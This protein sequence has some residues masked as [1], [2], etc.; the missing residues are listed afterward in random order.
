M[1]RLA[2]FSVALCLCVACLGPGT[3]L[4]GTNGQQLDVLSCQTHYIHVYGYNQNNY[5]NPDG[6]RF[7]LSGCGWHP[8]NGMWWKGPMWIYAYNSAGKYLGVE[9]TRVPQSQPGNYYPAFLP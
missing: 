4:A 3:A 5:W 1:K 2:A 6:W 8:I 7:T 9:Y